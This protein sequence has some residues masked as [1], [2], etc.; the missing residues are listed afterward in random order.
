MC[1]YTYIISYIVFQRI[2]LRIVFANVT[3]G[4]TFIILQQGKTLAN[5]NLF[6]REFEEVLV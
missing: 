6:H 2:P 5:L 4:Q 3:L 1:L